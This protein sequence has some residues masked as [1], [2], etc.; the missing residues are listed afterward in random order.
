MQVAKNHLVLVVDEYGGVAGLVTMEDL[1]E[2]L[3]GDI[4]DEYDRAVV[5]RTEVEPGIWR[6]SARLPIDELGDLFGIELD[7]DDV[8]TAGGLLTKELGHLAVSGDTVTV[9]GVVLTADR[10]EGKRRHLITVLAERTHALADV[11]DAFDDAE[12]TTTGTT[13]A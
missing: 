7:D 13:H 11:E 12:P 9:S 10:V 8:D 1:I 3:V 2:E 5:D 6:I 4:S